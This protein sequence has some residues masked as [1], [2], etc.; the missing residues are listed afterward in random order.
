MI[1]TTTCAACGD[2]IERLPGSCGWYA[3]L[4]A[5]RPGW[6]DH[7][8]RP[9]PAPTSELGVLKILNSNIAGIS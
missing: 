6:W 1:T 5:T 8:A 9:A 7:E 4:G 3:H 2:P